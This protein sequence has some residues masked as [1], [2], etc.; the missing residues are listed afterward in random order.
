MSEQDQQDQQQTPESPQTGT[1]P[2]TGGENSGDA[3][4]T[5]DQV[6]DIIAE[7]LRRE[8]E[9]YADYDDLKAK[10]SK[11]AE[12]EDAQKS[13]LEKAQERAEAL[14]R[15]AKAQETKYRADL[16]RM[17]ARVQ[18][19]QMGFMNPDDAYALAE[20]DAVEIG[21][22]GEIEGVKKALEALAKDKPYLLGEPPKPTPP[23]ADGNEGNPPTSGGVVLTAQDQAAIQAARASGY[24]IDE[25]AI[26]RRKA[27]IASKRRK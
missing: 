4:L 27:D 18:A 23:N 7:R 2:E 20:L 16:I 6:N 12:Y 3:K 21:E 19:A 17:E 22:T 11:W 5:Q 14:E 9:K 13:E 10:A 8:R 15:A 25:D 26:R 1:P 24:K